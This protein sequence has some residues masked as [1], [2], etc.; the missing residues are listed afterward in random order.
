[1]CVDSAHRRYVCYRRYVCVCI[2]L[3]GGMYVC[4]RRYVCVC[5]MLTGGMYVCYR[6]YVCVRS[7]HR[8]YVC[9]L[10]EVCM[11]AHRRC[12]VRELLRKAISETRK[13]RVPTNYD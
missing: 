6:R 8:R 9:V 13:E 11:C 12:L 7:A 3:T 10:Q 5:V 2:V 1:M 4:Y